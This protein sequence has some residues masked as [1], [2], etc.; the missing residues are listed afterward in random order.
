MPYEAD[1]H[2]NGKIIAAKW[3][4]SGVKKTT[5]L[6]IRLQTEH[7]NIDH[8][9]WVSQAAADM[10]KRQMMACGVQEMDLVAKPFWDDPAPFVVGNVTPFSTVAEEGWIKVKWVGGNADNPATIEAKERA[11]SI[12]CAKLE[13]EPEANDH[14]AFISNSDVPF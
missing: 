4:E 8:T 9:I 7:G 14:G 6:K 11:R 10:A 3:I 12:F 5:G 13:P 1:K 2:Y